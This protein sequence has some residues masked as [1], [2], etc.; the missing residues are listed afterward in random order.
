MFQSVTT[1]GVNNITCLLQHSSHVNRVTEY[2][3]CAQSLSSYPKFNLEVSTFSSDL[4]ARTVVFIVP[5]AETPFAYA[6]ACCI[7]QANTLAMQNCP[8]DLT[9]SPPVPVI[10]VYGSP[11]PTSEEPSVKAESPQIQV[12]SPRT[13]SLQ[14]SD[15]P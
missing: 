2:S 5:S 6:R 15:L 8:V 9:R 11:T 13:S 7:L 14:R 4:I 10:Q 3:M 1:G 12:M